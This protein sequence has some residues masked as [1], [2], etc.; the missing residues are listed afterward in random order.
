MS[1]YRE[2]YGI[3]LHDH[4]YESTHGFKD[5]ALIYAEEAVSS[6]WQP[7]ESP[8]EYDLVVFNIG[9]YPVHVGIMVDNKRFIHAHESC[10]VA[11]ESVESIKWRSR[12][13]GYYRHA[14]AV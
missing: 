5:N 7:T 2:Q 1:I 14:D 10:D 6:K 13:N 9:G 12:V 8:K 4:A 11:I 3:E